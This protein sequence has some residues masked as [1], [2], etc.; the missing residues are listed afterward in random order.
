MVA[1]VDQLAFL[2]FLGSTCR[3]LAIELFLNFSLLG[4][5]LLLGELCGCFLFTWLC[6]AKHF[7]FKLDLLATCTSRFTSELLFF[8]VLS[9]AYCCISRIL[10]LGIFVGWQLVGVGHSVFVLL[11]VALS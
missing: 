10:A 9:R 5:C 6:L 4:Q 11:V 7:K 3:V 1:P 8:Q 2:E